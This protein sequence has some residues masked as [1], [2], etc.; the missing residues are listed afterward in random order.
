M[1]GTLMSKSTLESARH[2]RLFVLMMGVV[3]ICFGV[4]ISA[5]VQRSL[6]LTNNGSITTFGSALTEN[7][8]ALGNPSPSPTPWIDNVTIPGWY[9]SRTTY[10]GGNG[11][12]NTGSLYSFGVAGV[13]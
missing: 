13:N 6:A 12:S 9:S 5:L 2:I 3:A 1:R 10:G 11:S 7:F 4:V 8:D